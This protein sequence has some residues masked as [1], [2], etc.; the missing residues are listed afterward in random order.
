MKILVPIDFSEESMNAIEHA[1]KLAQAMSSSLTLLLFRVQK[2]IA[3]EP[4]LPA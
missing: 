1:A 3:E 2:M 4:L